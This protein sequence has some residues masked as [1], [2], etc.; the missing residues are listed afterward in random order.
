[1]R[2]TFQQ[3]TEEAVR[4]HPDGEQASPEELLALAQQAAL[5]P[6][7]DPLR[8]ARKAVSELR[9]Q[10]MRAAAC[11]AQADSPAVT[12]RRRKQALA[13]AREHVEQVRLAPPA[14]L[15]ELAEAERDATPEPQPARRTG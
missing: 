12:P 2:R 11:L 6:L 8:E 1:V 9:H 3:A 14:A 15:L 4:R 13:A 10:A 7:A 5:E